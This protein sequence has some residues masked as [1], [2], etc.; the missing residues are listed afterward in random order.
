MRGGWLG[1]RLRTSAHRILS[2]T[3]VDNAESAFGFQAATVF[4]KAPILAVQADS[5]WPF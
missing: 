2:A 3:S 5:L 1:I 4:V